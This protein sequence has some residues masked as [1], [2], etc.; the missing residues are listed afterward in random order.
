M[1]E[2]LVEH[3]KAAH[4]A[5]EYPALGEH[6]GVTLVLYVQVATPDD[7]PPVF[8]FQVTPYELVVHEAV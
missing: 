3:V 8:A 7:V 2:L 4:V 5:V 1:N 6:V